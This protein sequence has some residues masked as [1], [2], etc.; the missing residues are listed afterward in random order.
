LYLD[1]KVSTTRLWS[2]ICYLITIL[3]FI[4]D[5]VKKIKPK[6]GF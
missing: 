4:G 6:I 2:N 3:T 1:L 5:K